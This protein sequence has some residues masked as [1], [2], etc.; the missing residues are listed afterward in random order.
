ML[1]EPA[2]RERLGAYS[3]QDSGQDGGKDE[4]Q[5]LLATTYYAENGCAGCV[6]IVRAIQRDLISRLGI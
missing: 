2:K 1:H 4:S 3:P 6:I 5:G